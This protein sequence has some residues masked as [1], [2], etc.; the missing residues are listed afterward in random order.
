MLPVSGMWYHQLDA[1]VLL[2]EGV[3]PIGLTLGT[4]P[5]YVGLVPF[6]YLPGTSRMEALVQ[7]SPSDQGKPPIMGNVTMRPADDERPNRSLFLW[8]SDAGS[9][10]ARVADLPIIGWSPEPNLFDIVTIP[11]VPADRGP[12]AGA[13]GRVTLSPVPWAEAPLAHDYNAVIKPDD[14]EAPLAEFAATTP[15]W[16]DLL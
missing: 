9:P 15:A 12:L 6:S 16:E 1:G 8:S 14:A 5:Y 3:E 4:S 7:R 13:V 2:P 11:R 10:L